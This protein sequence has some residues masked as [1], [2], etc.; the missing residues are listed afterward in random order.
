MNPDKVGKARK[1]WLGGATHRQVKERHGLTDEEEFA[2]TDCSDGLSD[3]EVVDALQ[4]VKPGMPGGSIREI[5]KD[6]K[7]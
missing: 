7:R 1:S 6:H 4:H 2:I 3:K 5:L